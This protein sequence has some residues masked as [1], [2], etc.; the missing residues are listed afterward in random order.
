MRLSKVL[1]KRKIAAK[2]FDAHKRRGIV[3]R[4]AGCIQ[5]LTLIMAPYTGSQNI[6]S[7]VWVL[8]KKEV[9]WSR[10]GGGFRWELR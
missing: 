10:R 2:T 9:E 3:M 6:D 7:D 5:Q 1:G 4:V 8:A